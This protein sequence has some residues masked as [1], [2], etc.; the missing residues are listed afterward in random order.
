[1]WVGWEFDVAPREG[2]M[3]INT[4]SAVGITGLVRATYTPTERGNEGTFGDLSGYTPSDAAAAANTLTVRDAPEMAPVSIP[5]DRW[6]LAGNV[7]TLEGGFEP[8]R[9][10]EL[11]YAVVN[12]PVAG[13][14]LAASAIP[15]RG[16]GTPPIRSRRSVRDHVWIVAERPVP[17]GVSVRGLQHGRTQPPGVRRRHGAHRWRQPHRSQSAI[18]DADKPESVHD[19][20][21][22]RRHEAARSGNGRRRGRA[23]QPRA[24]EHQPKVFYTN[25]GVEYWGGGRVAAL[26]HTTP[27]GSKDLT[28]P[29]NERAY[30]LSGS[31]HGPARFPSS[32]ANG[33]QK[34]NPNDYWW[35]MRALLVAMDK[36][37]REGV[38]PPETRVPR[39]QDSTLVRADDVMFPDLPGVASPTRLTAGGR[40]ANRLI[41][42][43]GAPGTPMP[44]L[45]P[46]VDRD[47]NERAGIRLPDIAVPLATYTG[48]NF[49]NAKIGGTDQLFPLL[50][51]Y[52]PFAAT[53]RDRDHRG[54]ARVNRGALSKPRAISGAG[55]GGC[56]GP[57]EG[58]VPAGRRR[59]RADQACGRPL[60][61]PRAA[62]SPIE[63]RTIGGEDGIEA[64]P[65]IE[66]VGV[67]IAAAFLIGAT[68]V[69]AATACEDL[70]KVS[71]SNTTI[72]LARA[73]TAGAFTPPQPPG[74]APAGG[75]QGSAFKDLPTFCQ[76]QATL[77]P[78]ADSEIKVEVWL[79]AA[80]S[81]NGKLQGVGNGGMGGGVGVNPVLLA[82]G[83][84]RGYAT[85]GTNS[86]HEGDSTYAIGHPEKVKDWGWRAYHEMTVTAKALIKAH[87]EKPLLRSVVAQVGG[88]AKLGLN[89]A[90]RFPEDYDAIV[91]TNVITS[92][93]RSA[94]FQFWGWMATH[95]TEGS[96]LPMQK[97]RVLHQAV[98]DACDANDGL[99]DGLIGQP[100]RCK[101]DPGVVQCSGADAA[102]CLTPPQIA[103][104]RK[105]YSG[106]VNPRTKE[107][108]ASPLFPGGELGWNGLAGAPQPSGVATGWFKGLV[109]QD[110]A[111]DYRTRPVNF[112]ADVAAS[113]KV[114]DGNSPDPDLRKFFGKRRQTAHRQWLGRGDDAPDSRDR[115]LQE[116][117]REGG[118]KARPRL[119][120]PVRR[121]GNGPHSGHHRCGE[122]QLRCVE[123][124]RAVGRHWKGAGRSDRRP[125]Q[126]RDAHRKAPRVSVSDGR[127]LPGQREHGRSIQLPLQ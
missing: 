49:R 42:R 89:A 121:S 32:I 73:V 5:R 1:M 14:G 77:R 99:A 20:L 30:L 38:A 26:I 6:K 109:F 22:V 70:A 83:V 107:K 127:R 103:A 15:H 97:L 33:Q 67:S 113:D 75:G 82:G 44:L 116:C 35:T 50:G 40:G 81:W 59:A 72:T 94:V 9:I 118:R 126:R 66:V 53:K 63:R 37:V 43:E 79:P 100:E 28:L 102:N 34:D 4:P 85:V 54:S 36:W 10:Y 12:P 41:A 7:V 24:K 61:S 115:L 57:R 51:S 31:Q 60:G 62:S 11:A 29:A 19:G 111:W 76:V 21:P 90:Q 45:I 124:H 2:A 39:L 117:R 80:A 123:C 86:G 64:S 69:A 106:P 17:A 27:D 119:D 122:L 18:F 104:A 48:W 8:G 46:Q 108:L 91:S 105:L 56:R 96:A 74:P 65:R 55:A 13:L 112:D 88:E 84:R 92:F 25:T 93:S 3:R 58:A 120:A 125:L 95:E 16:S 47:G 23:R 110:P 68:P 98:L 52:I 78:T 71:L 101:F 87:Y 114:V